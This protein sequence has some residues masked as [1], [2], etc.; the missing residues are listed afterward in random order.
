MTIDDSSRDDGLDPSMLEAART[1]H[2][3]PPTVP[4]ETMWA[5]IERQRRDL[6]RAPAHRAAPRSW[7]STRLS[8]PW[9][10]SAAAV[11]VLAT[12]IALG[13]AVH[14]RAKTD[15]VSVPE[16][17][18]ATTEARTSDAAYDIAL[19]RNLT[20]VEA[21]LTAYHTAPDSKA[22]ADLQLASWAR[23]LLSNTRLLLDSPVGADPMRHRLLEDL[24]LVLAQMVQLPSDTANVNRNMI[25]QTLDRNHLLLRLRVAVP[26]GGSGT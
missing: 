6:S 25:D 15:R 24:E 26:A 8:H 5:A 23:D 20:Q 7:T 1:Y 14:G 12:G 4:R 11:V 22:I 16:A 2:E 19:T 9:I 17:R 3:P 10:L 13:W 18:M 21:L